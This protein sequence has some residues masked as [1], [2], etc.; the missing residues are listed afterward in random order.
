M[1]F[2]NEL[3]RLDNRAESAEQEADRWRSKFVNCDRERERLERE[4]VAANRGNEMIAQFFAVAPGKDLAETAQ[5]VADAHNE[6][7]RGEVER[8]TEDV[9]SKVYSHAYQDF[10]G[11]LRDELSL[12]GCGSLEDAIKELKERRRNLEGVD[13]E[14]A[15]LLALLCKELK[16]IAPP[17]QTSFEDAIR[18]LKERRKN[19]EDAYNLAVNEKAAAKRLVSEADETL[20]AIAKLACP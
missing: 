8:K 6:R 12:P 5:R 20:A 18:E 3:L 13:K 1:D 15:R 19:L 11:K 4:L 2:A 16:L 14:R 7:M 10:L 17:A 9:Y